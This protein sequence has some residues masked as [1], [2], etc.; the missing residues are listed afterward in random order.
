MSYNWALFWFVHNWSDVKAQRSRAKRG[1]GKADRKV[2]M[3]QKKL[4]LSTYLEG[5]LRSV[6]VCLR[7]RLC[8]LKR[9]RPCDHQ[10]P[11]SNS[12]VVIGHKGWK[13]LPGTLSI[14]RSNFSCYLRPQIFNFCLF[15]SVSPSGF[16]ITRAWS[17][18]KNM[19][20]AS[21]FFSFVTIHTKRIDA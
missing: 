2:A 1:W 9:K 4:S 13:L 15:Y 3:G 19:I 10:C 6:D 8:A 21:S 11:S 5:F 7:C 14:V 16:C 18:G 17:S 20:E 12:S